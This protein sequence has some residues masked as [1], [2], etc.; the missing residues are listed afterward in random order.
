MEEGHV[1]LDSR[2]ERCDFCER[3]SSDDSAE[4]KLRELGLFLASDRRAISPEQL[5]QPHAV[6]CDVVLRVKLSP[7]WA[8]DPQDAACRAQGLFNWDRYESQAEFAGRFAGFLVERDIGCGTHDFI[9]F[10]SQLE[11]ITR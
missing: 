8:K 7:I 3:Y 5:V 10:N 1:V 11:E 9:H 4:A 6:Y 2:V